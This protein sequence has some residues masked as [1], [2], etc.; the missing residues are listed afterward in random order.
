MFSYLTIG[1]FLVFL[2]LVVGSAYVVFNFQTLD[3]SG[4]LESTIAGLAALA[5]LTLAMWPILMPVAL[6]IGIGFAFKKIK[7][8]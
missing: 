3:Y 8:D 4:D 5:A 1:I 2:I 7:G 6:G